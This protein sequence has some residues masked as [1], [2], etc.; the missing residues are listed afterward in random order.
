[1]SEKA[2]RGYSSSPSMARNVVSI[3]FSF[4]LA[5]AF[6]VIGLLLIVQ[7]IRQPDFISGSFDTQY[8]AYVKTY[9]EDT[10]TDYTIPT[11]I[12]VNVLNGVFTTEKIQADT[13]QAIRA[14]FAGTEFTPDTAEMETLLANQTKAFFYET[15]M[16]YEN[17]D[18]IVETYVSE[19]MEFYA[20][21][22]RLPGLSALV[23]IINRYSRF[24][25]PAMAA[26]AVLA[27][28]LLILCLRLHRWLHRG[29]R[30]IAYATGGAFLITLTAP[31][32]LYLSRLYERLQIS[33]Q[34]FYYCVVNYVRRSLEVFLAMA[35]IWLILTV[36]LLIIIKILRSRALRKGR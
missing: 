26:A 28:I 16:E 14:T 2:K 13:Y 6:T 1:M 30:Y 25:W 36:I 22:F 5:I 29:L 33:P 32:V 11:S 21:A 9:L 24:F 23:T 3:L 15:G 12:D 8:T 35:A 17:A 10:T 31:L 27:L 20:G 19:I 7:L 4:L 34:Y 18:A